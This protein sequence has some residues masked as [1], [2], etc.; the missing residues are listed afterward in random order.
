MASQ[1]TLP[2]WAFLGLYIAAAAVLSAVFIAV[3]EPALL[4]LLFGCPLVLASIVYPPRIYWTALVI[5]SGFACYAL[6]RLTSNLLLTTVDAAGMALAVVGVSAAIKRLSHQRIDVERGLDGVFRGIIQ[7]LDDGIVIADPK[8]IITFVN[9]RMEQ[10]LGY[11]KEQAVGLPVSGLVL[12]PGLWSD[13]DQQ[14]QPLLDGV[15][16]AIEQRWTPS[17]G[18]EQW[19]SIVSRPLYDSSSKPIGTIFTFANITERKAVNEAFAHEHNRL[20]MLIKT[21]P[22]AVYYKDL[23]GRYERINAAEAAELGIVELSHAVGKTDADFYDAGV[24]SEA[25]HDEQVI[26]SSGIPLRNKLEVHK[27]TDGRLVYLS[28]TKVRVD[29]DAGNAIG[30]VGISRDVTAQ[31][32]AENA[33]RSSEEQL[34]SLIAS[35]DDLIFSINLNGRFLFYHQ[36]PKTSLDDTPI[37]PP[38]VIVGKHISDILPDVLSEKLLGTV[39]EVTSTLRT[40]Q[41][42]YSLIEDD[43]ERFYSARV[44]PLIDSSITLIGLT[45]V[46]S[47]VTATVESARRQQR[48]LDFEQLNRRVMARFLQSADPNTAMGETI[49]RFAQALDATRCYVFH[50]RENERLMDNTYEWHIPEIGDERPRMQSIAFDEHIP[51]LFHLLSRNGMLV[52]SRLDGLPHDLVTFFE[53]RDVYAALILPFYVDKRLQGFVGFDETR[54]PRPWMP[55]EIAAVRTVTQSYE[56]ALERQRADLALIEARDSALRSARLKSE[57]MS[58]MS[59]EIRTPLTGLLGMLELLVETQLD[60]MQ[61][62]L[63]QTALQSGQSLRRILNDIL[64]FS[65]I[66]AGKVLLESVP[67]DLRGMVA[68]VRSTLLLEATNKQLDFVTEIAEP[69]PMRVLCDPTRLRQVLINLT[70]NAIKFTKDGSVKIQIQQI[71]QTEERSL[72][73][74]EIHDTGIGIAPEQITRIFESF[75][76]ADGSITR[77][78][79]GTG[80][81]LAICKQLVE[82]M[83]G[84]I[85]VQSTVGQGSIFGFSIGFPFLDDHRRTVPDE[86]RVLII[87]EENTPRRVLA[88][89]L[90]GLGA[91]IMESVNIEELPKQLTTAAMFSKPIHTVIIQPQQ[92]TMNIAGV[93]NSIRTQLGETSP[94]FILMRNE[95]VQLDIDPGVFDADLTYPFRPSELHRIIWPADAMDSTEPVRSTARGAFQKD[96]TPVPVRAR[97]LVAEDDETNRDVIR[98]S[99]KQTRC[100]ADIVESGQEALDCLARNSYDLVFMDIRMPGMDGLETTRLIRQQSG[101][102]SKIP[103]IAVTASVM[104]TETK[105]YIEAGMN[106]VLE[107]PFSIEDLRNILDRWLPSKSQA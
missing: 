78:F 87:A 89:H 27:K 105:R 33:L 55:E 28:T 106:G 29:D 49:Q 13:A 45:V 10:L 14:L 79:G 32:K 82:L 36:S 44:S 6:L 15:V 92:T 30:V 38:D 35:I 61:R 42:T 67:T 51:S 34:R 86:E 66:E 76:Q 74:F 52:F 56:R 73:Q 57:F 2:T 72:L 47:D 68:E 21:V 98:R 5:G 104:P 37:T 1:K 95:D 60:E 41:F 39:S 22:D 75:V 71:S 23:Q 46:A 63:A 31:I 11:P 12:S 91:V 3:D 103:I 64:D 4:L 20:D 77:K 54:K 53:A 18:Q 81:G 96:D 59:H 88:R 102:R 50:F 40:H 19:L 90:R 58:N 85:D 80:L 93:V 69:V 94:R 62:D 107:K 65:R 84:R 97:V 100:T 8:R 70:S 7:N 99:L 16:Q 9:A 43:E 17:D 48:L 83:G 24:S 25:A 101:E 26:I